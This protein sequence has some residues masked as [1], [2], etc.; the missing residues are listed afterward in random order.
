MALHDVDDAHAVHK[1][2]Q[3]IVGILFKTLFVCLDTS[4]YKKYNTFID[5]THNTVY[6]VLFW[7]NFH[8]LAN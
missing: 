1:R 6:T 4:S 5:F 7:V 2:L 8:F 3:V